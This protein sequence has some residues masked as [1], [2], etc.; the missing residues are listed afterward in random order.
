MSGR[1]TFARERS[2]RTLVLAKSFLFVG[3]GLL[4]ATCGFSSSDKKLPAQKGESDIAGPSEVLKYAG[5]E[6]AQNESGHVPISDYPRVSRP[7]TDNGFGAVMEEYFAAEKLLAQGRIADARKAADELTA[8]YPDHLGFRVFKSDVLYWSGNL[9]E[10]RELLAPIVKGS[11]HARLFAR[12]VLLEVDEHSRVTSS[13][14]ASVAY[15]YLDG[16]HEIYEQ[17]IKALIHAP[18]SKAKWA[19]IIG[20]IEEK[21]SREE[22]AGRFLEYAENSGLEN[23]MVSFAR[24][25]MMLR[26][27]LYE[28]TIRQC[29]R[30]VRIAKTPKLKLAAQD[31]KMI[32]K[33]KLE[34]VRDAA[35]NIQP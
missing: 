8:D 22:C 23:G 24:Q 1:N 30:T 25:R 27:G 21:N 9:E 29:E 11:G 10:A 12:M 18:D 17:D 6:A 4:A 16:R 31:D 34:E 33:T 20:L 32:A 35:G 28:D 15:A 19:A 3:V 13:E 14:M 26:Q 2:G 7:T 5:G